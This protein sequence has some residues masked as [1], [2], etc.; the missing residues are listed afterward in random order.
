MAAHMAAA[1]KGAVDDRV[2][3]QHQRVWCTVYA[4]CHGDIRTYLEGLV[5]LSAPDRDPDECLPPFHVSMSGGPDEFSA[6]IVPI[7]EPEGLMEREAMTTM[8]DPQTEFVVVYRASPFWCEYV[9]TLP[10]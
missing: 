7:L 1:A 8:C 4:A 3:E 5:T 6:R 10:F 9:T 2:A